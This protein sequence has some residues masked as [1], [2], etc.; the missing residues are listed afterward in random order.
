[1]KLKKQEFLKCF[2]GGFLQ[3]FAIKSQDSAFRWLVGYSSSTPS[4]S[5]IYLNFPNFLS[6]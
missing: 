3:I 6:S 1:M 4:I 2:T 5:G